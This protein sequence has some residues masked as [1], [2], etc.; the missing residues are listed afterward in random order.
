MYLSHGEYFCDDPGMPL[1]M[2]F[3]KFTPPHA[4]IPHQNNTHTR[5]IVSCCDCKVLDRKTNIP[6]FPSCLSFQKTCGVLFIVKYSKSYSMV[7]RH[8][9]EIASTS[10]SLS[11]VRGG[12]G[13]VFL[14]DIYPPNLGAFVKKF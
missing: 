8:A 12:E 5:T 7:F 9:I 10:V 6:K 14:V 3:T 11:W 2:V 1:E 13:G 4:H